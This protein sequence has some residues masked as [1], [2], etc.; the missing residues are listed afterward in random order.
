MADI[1]QCHDHFPR[2]LV[3]RGLLRRNVRAAEAKALLRVHR[4]PRMSMCVGGAELAEVEHTR[5]ARTKSTSA[6][7]IACIILEDSALMAFPQFVRPFEMNLIA[8]CH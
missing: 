1:K 3:L 7:T 4:L 2:D 8:R 6:G 5:G